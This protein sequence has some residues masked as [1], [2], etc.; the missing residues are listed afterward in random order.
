[1]TIIL[2]EGTYSVDK[3]ED[4]EFF[5]DNSL[6]ISRCQPGKFKVWSLPQF[7]SVDF[8]KSRI[9]GKKCMF[10]KLTIKV[11]VDCFW[12]VP[13]TC[14]P[15]V[16]VSLILGSSGS[17]ARAKSRAI[18]GYTQLKNPSRVQVEDE[19]VAGRNGRPK[20][21]PNE[22]SLIRPASKSIIFYKKLTEKNWV[23]GQTWLVLGGRILSTWPTRV[24]GLLEKVEKTYFLRRLMNRILQYYPILQVAWL[25]EKLKS[26]H[27]IGLP[28]ISWN[29]RIHCFI[30]IFRKILIVYCT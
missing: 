26:A 15:S 22:G 16:M 9:G 29:C 30:M 11:C 19:G 7:Y 1:M 23:S 12:R 4:F 24:P 20:Y 28:Q 21:F 18:E 8:S 17:N 25:R 3:C 2:F 13:G 6:A 5:I 10:N 14:L 27:Q